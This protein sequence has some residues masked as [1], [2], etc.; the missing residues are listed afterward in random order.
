MLPSKHFFSKLFSIGFCFR[1]FR[2]VKLIP[3][4]KRKANE[5]NGLNMASASF[6]SLILVNQ[7]L[8]LF[9]VINFIINPFTLFL[10]WPALCFRTNFCQSLRCKVRSLKSLAMQ[11]IFLALL[12]M[13]AL[14][15][16]FYIYFF[17]LQKAVVVVVIYNLFYFQLFPYL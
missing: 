10:L 1:A 17:H 3:E 16:I 6:H 15:W 13:L 12:N 8:Y 14:H 11:A 5:K 2:I 4:I 9:R 7:A